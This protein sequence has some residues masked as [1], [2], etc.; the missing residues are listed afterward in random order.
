MSNDNQPMTNIQENRLSQSFMY[1]KFSI[2]SKFDYE[3]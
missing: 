3:V 2:L 1:K